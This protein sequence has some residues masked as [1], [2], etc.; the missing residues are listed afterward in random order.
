[1]DS[2][3]ASLGRQEYNCGN[4][5][6]ATIATFS[7]CRS[8]WAMCRLPVVLVVMLVL[9]PVP[10]AVAMLWSFIALK[11]SFLPSGFELTIAIMKIVVRNL[12]IF[13]IDEND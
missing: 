9:V 4:E 3:K 6:L 2:I 11:R 10:D 1:M 5:R 12:S 13:D 7:H 8:D